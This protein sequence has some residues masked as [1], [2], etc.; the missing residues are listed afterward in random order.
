MN[1]SLHKAIYDCFRG[2]PPKSLAKPWDLTKILGLEYKQAITMEHNLAP[3]EIKGEMLLTITDTKREVIRKP[4]LK[5]LGK[6]AKKMNKPL[7]I[8]YKLTL[9]YQESNQ[10]FYLNQFFTG[11]HR[12]HCIYDTNLMPVHHISKYYACSRTFGIYYDGSDYNE[13]NFADGE[14]LKRPKNGLI[15]YIWVKC[16]KDDVEKRLK[17]EWDSHHKDAKHIKKVSEAHKKNDRYNEKFYHPIDID[18]SMTNAQCALQ[19]FARYTPYLKDVFESIPNKEAWFIE[20]AQSGGLQYAEKGTYENAYCYDVNKMYP[21]ILSNKCELGK[22][23][24]DSG[25]YIP[26]KEGNY[27]KLNDITEVTSKYGNV[28][29]GIYQCEVQFEAKQNLFRMSKLDHYTHYD[30][31]IAL[32]LGGKIT[33]KDKPIN[34]ILYPVE[35]RIKSHMVFGKYYENLMDLYPDIKKKSRPR[36]KILLNSLWGALCQKNVKNKLIRDGEATE[37]IDLENYDIVNTTEVDDNLTKYKL[38]SKNKPYVHNYARLGPF[39]QAHARAC[40]FHQLHKYEKHIKRIH[41][42]GFVADKEL[43]LT[44][45]EEMGGWKIEKQGDVRIENINKLVWNQKN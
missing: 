11:V 6:Y 19:L 5:R 40:M 4:N 28:Q 42:D 43:D 7:I 41:T 24:F 14:F 15:K 31:N 22:G 17:E 34:A 16:K 18:H 12:K 21:S 38:H 25:F 13:H 45:S 35:Y 8:R 3:L 32:K 36:F 10:C 2:K 9:I 39:I 23:N 37:P 20:K 29:Y 44:I 26:F 27:H 33:M 1:N 30:L